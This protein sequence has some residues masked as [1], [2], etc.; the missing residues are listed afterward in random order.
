MVMMVRRYLGLKRGKRFEFIFLTKCLRCGRVGMFKT[1]NPGNHRELVDVKG[2][3]AGLT[4]KCHLN[5]VLIV[6]KFSK[7]PFFF[8]IYFPFFFRFIFNFTPNLS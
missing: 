5:I 7:F 8:P 3:Y 6:Y 1:N 2:Q 4:E